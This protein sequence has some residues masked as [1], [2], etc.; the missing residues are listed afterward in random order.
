MRRWVVASEAWLSTYAACSLGLRRELLVLIALLFVEFV[1][2]RQVSWHSL[3]AS[4][5]WRF[6]QVGLIG[7]ARPAK[8]ALRWHLAAKF[9]GTHWASNECLRLTLPLSQ[10]RDPL[11]CSC[12]TWRPWD[13]RKQGTRILWNCQ[14]STIVLL[15]FA[16]LYD[17]ALSLTSR[18]VI[19]QVGIADGEGCRWLPLVVLGA[20]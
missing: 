9:R 12:I 2:Q 10:F 11:W 18:I 4:R 5:V 15:L 20:T 14:Y 6:L 1:G 3:V 19:V 7:S 17:H 8:L 13:L 16:A